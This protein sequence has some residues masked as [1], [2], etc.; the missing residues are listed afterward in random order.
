MTE[1]SLR[2]PSPRYLELVDLYRQMHGDAKPGS[3][4]AM[5]GAFAGNSL[6]RHIPMIRRLL[7]AT[8]S[9]TVLDYGSGKG[10][11][12]AARNIRFGLR[13]YGSVQDYW[14]VSEVACYDPAYIHYS[15]LPDRTFDA[16]VT[17]DVMEHVPAEDVDWV[18]RE[19]FAYAR[20]LVFGNIACFPATK[21][22]PNGE[23]AHCTTFGPEI[24]REKIEAARAATKSSV[25]YLFVATELRAP[26]IALS[27]KP[28]RV[29][30]HTKISNRAD[31]S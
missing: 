21:T 18:L 4:E 17:T 19:I 9:Q 6:K 26:R 7:R 24:W 30:V 20:K 3:P 22:L 1:I 14:G 8:G 12:Y 5:T 15:T 25:D 13:T 10:A 27:K 31:W 29:R 23:N 2:D 16:V 28:R 11:Q